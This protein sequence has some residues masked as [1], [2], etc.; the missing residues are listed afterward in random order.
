MTEP[1]LDRFSR[2]I[3]SEQPN[4]KNTLVEEE[5]D[6]GEA[7][8]DILEGLMCQCCGALID[9]EEPVYPRNCEDCE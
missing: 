1:N 6:L 9:G 8:D 7:V 3:W 2:P 5:S 4:R